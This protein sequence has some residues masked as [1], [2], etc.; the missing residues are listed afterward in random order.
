MDDGEVVKHNEIKEKISNRKNEVKDFVSQEALN[1][2]EFMKEIWDTEN[3]LVIIERKRLSQIEQELRARKNIIDEV[4]EKLKPDSVFSIVENISREIPEE[5]AL[6]IQPPDLIYI[7]GK[8]RFTTEVLESVI[9]IPE[10]VLVQTFEYEELKKVYEEKCVLLEDLK[11]KI[12]ECHPFFEKKAAKI[13]KMDDDEVKRHNDIKDKICNKKSEI[14]DAVTKESVNLIGAMEGIWDTENNPLVTERE[15]L[16]QI[17]QELQTR[18]NTLHDA[19]ED[20][21]PA[22]VFSTVETIKKDIPEKAYLKIQPPEL[23]YIEPEEKNMT[24][25]LGST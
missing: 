25:V 1:L 7:E 18:Q 22:S 23:V 24:D 20:K 11:R 6:D 5:T 16:S 8:E 15:R 19:L 3:N 10:V 12:D 14:K 2:E 13:R 4:I 9:K 17:E 21:D